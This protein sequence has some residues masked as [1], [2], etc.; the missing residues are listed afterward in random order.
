MSPMP[1]FVQLS[2]M[3]MPLPATGE[4]GFPRSQ[5]CLCGR[6]CALPKSRGTMTDTSSWK[7]QAS[8]L[9]ALCCNWRRRVTSSE[10]LECPNCGS[11]DLEEVS[12][13]E[14]RCLFCGSALMSRTPA[15]EW[16]APTYVRCPTCGYDNERGARYCSECG[17]VLARWVPTARQRTDPAVVS[18]IVTIGAT[19]AFPF[20]AIIGLILAYRALREARATSEASGSESL[21]RSAVTVGWIGIAFHVVPLCLVLGF[22]GTSLSWTICS[23]LLDGL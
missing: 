14:H 5:S 13:N 7:A 10:F 18:I 17:T 6:H 12:L 1:P 8:Y 22:S 4:R 9:T 21:A 3:S 11:T 20:G 23:G 2:R 16:A 19:L 15:R